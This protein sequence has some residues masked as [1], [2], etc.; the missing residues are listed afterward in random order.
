MTAPVEARPRI[1]GVT[2]TIR[3]SEGG[4]STPTYECHTHEAR[5]DLIN[6][7]FEICEEI[8]ARV[9]DVQFIWMNT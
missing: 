1:T 9:L 7:T 5:M 4:L 8:G 2:F 3:N 6:S